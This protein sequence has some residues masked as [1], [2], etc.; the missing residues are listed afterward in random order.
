MPTDE[1]DDDDRPRRPRDSR[2]DDEDRPARRRRDDADDYD[3]T[4][5]RGG[6]GKPHRG[7][8]ILVFGILSLLC[9]PIIFGLLAV[10]MGQADLK[11]MDAGRMDSSGR[12]LTKA[13]VIIGI[14]G[15]GLWIVWLILRFTVFAGKNMI[16]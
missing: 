2:D 5:R 1:Y 11:E 15:V 12:G 9:C 7:V 14:I 8:M 13:G 6:G 10:L 16:G 3:D 4:P